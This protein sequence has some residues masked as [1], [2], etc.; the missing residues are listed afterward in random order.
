MGQIGY[1]EPVSFE[2][3]EQKQE[4][5]TKTVESAEPEKTEQE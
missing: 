5:A 2:D 1:S 3:M 4:E